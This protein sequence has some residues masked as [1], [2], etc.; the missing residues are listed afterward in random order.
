MGPRLSNEISNTGTKPV[1][2]YLKQAIMTSFTFDCVSEST[3][4][5]VIKTLAAKNSTGIDSIS[6]NML[7]KLAP[8]VINPLT[9]IINQSLCTGIFPNR[10]KIA[11]VIPLFKK[12]DP[13]IFDNY[14][15]ISLLSSISKTFEKVVFNQVYAYFTNNDLFYN[16]QYG[17]RKLHSTEYASLEMVDRI[18]QYLDNGKLPITVYLDLSKAFDTINHEILLKKLKYYGFADTPL[19]WFESYL[20]NRQQHVFFNGCY[21]T[22]KTL[23]TGVPQGSILGPLLFLI[24]MNDLKEACNR[25]FP[26]L[27]ADDTG[28]VSSLC[29]FLHDEDVSNTCEISR[30]INDEL[31]CVQEWLNVNRLSLNVSKTKYMI[32]HHRQRKIDGFIPDIRINDSP[33]ERVTDFNFLGLQIDQHLNWNAHIQKCSNKISRTLGVMNR[34]KRYLPTKI[35]RVLYNSLILPHL[36]Y[37]IL[38]WGSKLSRLSKLQKRA[39]RVITCSKFNAHTEPLFKSL[40]LLKL[41]DLLYLNVLKLY[42]KLCHGDLPVY[43]TNLFTRIVPGSTHDYDLRQSGILKTPTVHTCVAERCVRFMLPK[44]INDADPSIIEKVYTHSFQGFTNYVKMIKIDSYA[45]HCLIANCYIC[46]HA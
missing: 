33:I 12:S 1:S 31:Y 20:H 10:L 38:S 22:P 14:R 25:F 27:Y 15:P 11:K 34:L 36:Q 29:S 26:I 30:N 37:A 21:S 32:F 4:M 41:E 3:V 19:K 28:L 2:A 46:Q 45:T 42:Y 18:S 16:S 39:T 13:H 40:K 24:Y 43:I 35:L 5:R 7:Q 17:F 44:I 23:E 8:V 6:T 9:H